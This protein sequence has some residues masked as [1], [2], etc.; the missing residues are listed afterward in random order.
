[1]NIE[2][3]EIII[4]NI[5]HSYTMIH[6]RREFYFIRIAPFL[7]SVDFRWG[8]DNSSVLYRQSSTCHSSMRT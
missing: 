7:K 8:G 6:S 3:S 5:V 4:A 1:M 2:L